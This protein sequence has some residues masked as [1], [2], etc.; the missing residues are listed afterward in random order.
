MKTVLYYNWIRKKRTFLKLIAEPAILLIFLFLLSIVIE[1]LWPSFNFQYLRWPQMLKDFFGLADWNRHL[2]VNLWQA[3]ALFYP[4]YIMYMLMSGLACSIVEEERLETVVYLYNMGID[5]K[6]VLI[7]KWAMWAAVSV[8]CFLSLLFLNI[9]FIL[10]LGAPLLIPML[11]KYHM[12]GLAVSFFY[13]AVAVFAASYKKQEQA[14]QDLFFGLVLVSLLISRIYAFLDF[15]ADLL[16]ATKRTGPLIDGLYAAASKLQVLTIIA[17]L[18]WCWPDM[19]VP[20]VFILC[21][22]VLGLLLMLGGCFLY[23][24]RRGDWR[25]RKNA[26]LVLCGI[27]VIVPA[28]QSVSLKQAELQMASFYRMNQVQSYYRVK[29]RQENRLVSVEH[30]P[31][32]NKASASLQFGSSKVEEESFDTGGNE[33]EAQEVLTDRQH[34]TVVANSFQQTSRNTDNRIVENQGPGQQIMGLFANYGEA[35]EQNEE[36]TYQYAVG[37]G[38]K[39]DIN[40]DR[41]QSKS[42]VVMQ[43]TYMTSPEREDS[44]SVSTGEPKSE[45][46]AEAADTSSQGK[47]AEA[48]RM[49]TSEDN[50][51][52]STVEVTTEADT[53]EG[54]KPEETKVPE[55][56][57]KT[58]EAKTVADK[59][60]KDVVL[61]VPTEEAA[62]QAE[63]TTEEE[64]TTEKEV[65]AEEKTTTEKETTTETATQAEEFGDIK[66]QEMFSTKEQPGIDFTEDGFY[67]LQAGSKEVYCTNRNQLAISAQAYQQASL[68]SGDASANGKGIAQICY[69]Y[70]DKIKY[71]TDGLADVKLVFP[72]EFYGSILAKCEDEEGASSQV[73]SRVV[74]IDPTP[75]DITFTKDSVCTAPYS[76]WMEVQEQGHI[77]SGIKQITCKVNGEDYK[78][79]NRMV[80]EHTMLNEELSVPAKVAVPVMLSEAGQYTVEITAE[81]YA[82]NVTV[83]SKEITVTEPELVSVYM[84]EQFT[85]HI[86]SRRLAGKEQIFSDDITLTNTSAF[87]VRVKIDEIALMIRDGNRES[88]IQKNCQIYL[89]APDTGQ[90]IPLE[91][92]TNTE[93]YAY[94]LPPGDSGDVAN[95]RLTGSLTEGS[96]ELWQDSDIMVTIKLSFEKWEE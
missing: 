23:G 46:A 78:I 91:K 24:Y 77:L 37:I 57:T 95:L 87:D 63:V 47:Q 22:L 13:L 82:G 39:A 44:Q 25:L 53:T 19:K 84:P 21:V 7:V 66:E 52:G 64:I 89:I 79:E 18:T 4:V 55:E 88:D 50:Q 90:K 56:E 80:Q 27:L 93:V 49:D 33:G 10:L 2:F 69:A 60:V 34:N 6:T 32:T 26:V 11:L 51:A 67:R 75:P 70:A 68:A 12:A 20:A 83:Q 36:E 54:I 62:T 9:V 72:K 30:T 85:V 38:R 17:P 16:I 15:F 14:C 31:N 59:T 45:D 28:V 41:M 40:Y 58:E 8:V 73:L 92:G 1:A 42:D 61:S 35:P 5:R 86:D 3:F 43:A 96:E 74:L 29:E 94:R 48:D 76:L 65:T 71:I 81:D